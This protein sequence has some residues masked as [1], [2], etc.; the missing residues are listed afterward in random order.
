MH[1]STA[2]V[3]ALAVGLGA[4]PAAA[5]EPTESGNVRITIEIGE[6]RAARKEA[7]RTYQ[8]VVQLGETAN[9][10]TGN[11]LPMPAQAAPPAAEGGTPA[12]SFSYQNVGVSGRLSARPVSE[13]RLLLQGQVQASLVRVSASPPIVGTFDQSWAVVM[14][15]GQPLRVAEV[16]DPETGGYY[17]DVRAD[18]LR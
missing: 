18:I 3:L 16:T 17:V 6:S 14:E 4:A 10:N 5:A 15:D 2:S 9:F 12:T 7:P 1:R 8:L 11:R 13:D